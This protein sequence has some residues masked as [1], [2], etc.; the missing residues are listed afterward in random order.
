MHKISAIFSES[1]AEEPSTGTHKTQRVQI[2]SK[3]LLGVHRAIWHKHSAAAAHV[4]TDDDR[5]KKSIMPATC[6][7]H[8][9]YGEINT[10]TQCPF[11]MMITEG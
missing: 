9:Q 3:L 11:F 2:F 8:T 10:E 6:G 5:P 7:S 4:P 1:R